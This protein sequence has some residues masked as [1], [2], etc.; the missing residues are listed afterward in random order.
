MAQVVIACS[1]NLLHY[2][3]RDL[4]AD[5]GAKTRVSHYGIDLDQPSTETADLASP[6]PGVPETYVFLPSRLV[7]KKSV[8]VAI[9]AVGVLKR[10]GLD[11]NLVIA[12]EGPV[13][14]N[15]EALARNSGV[16]AEVTFLG[17]VD[18]STSL[19]LMRRSAFVVV[20]SSWEAFGQVCLEA[21]AA[22]KAVIGS[23]NGGIGEI[24]LDGKTGLL[25]PPHDPEMLAAAIASLLQEPSRTAAMGSAG[26]QRA[27]DHFTWAQMVDRYEQAFEEA[28]SPVGASRWSLSG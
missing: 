4:Q 2:L 9:T 13:R 12:G 17:S 28:R 11:V 7:E 20:P 14:T 25:V 21:M 27:A 5:A 23:N 8:D 6:P 15:L 10:R 3:K 16:H 24:V 26:K 19:D 22:G 18:H 1:E